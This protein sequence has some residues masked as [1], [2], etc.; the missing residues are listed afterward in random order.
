M[1][2]G[3]LRKKPAI[4]FCYHEI[5]TDCIFCKIVA[6]EIPSFK[7]Y[8]DEAYLAF[9]DISQVVDGH[10]LLIPKEHIRWVW[11]VLPFGQFMEVAKKIVTRMRKVTGSEYVYTQAIGHL[12]EHAHLQLLPDTVGVH[13]EVLEKWKEALQTRHKSPEEMQKIADK[14][15]LD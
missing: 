1:V 3:T 8:E 11:D 9:L 4:N 14:F 15:K 13:N 10:T 6:G 7:I 12:V 2:R 5:M